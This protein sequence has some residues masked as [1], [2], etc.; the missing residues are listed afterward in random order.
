M[1]TLDAADPQVIG[2]Y[3][4]L[5]RLGSGGMGT[6]YL[7]SSRGGHRLAVKVI[8]GEL[9]NDPQFRV[10]F[11][12]EVEAAKRVRGHVTAAFVDSDTKALVPWL[13]TVYVDG[14]TLGSVVQDGPLD[15][16]TLRQLAAAVSEALL[17]IHDAG[18]VHRDL[19]PS[20]IILASDGARVIDFG[21]AQAMD[22]TSLTSTHTRIGSP[23][24]IAP[25]QVRDGTSSPAADVFSLG[26]VLAFA[27]TGQPV[28][29]EGSI[30][31][32]LYRVVHEQPNLDGVPEELRPLIQG[33]LAKDPALRPGLHEVLNLVTG[34]SSHTPTKTQVITAPRTTVMPELL[35]PEVAAGGPPTRRY[36]KLLLATGVAALLVAAGFIAAATVSSPDSSNSPAAP[37]H[38]S[39]QTSRVASAAPSTASQAPTS[40]QAPAPS[41]V[42][43]PPLADILK[44]AGA[45]Q[46]PPPFP[47]AAT[48]YSFSRSVQTTVRAFEGTKWATVTD[49]PATM[50]GCDQQRFYIR[51]RSLNPSA[52]IQATFV[53]S[54]DDIVLDAPVTGT[55][56]WQS[57]Y[58]CGQPAFRLSSTAS[59]GSTL[60][61][62]VVEYQ[63]WTASI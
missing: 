35:A 58:G 1:E 18:L 47:T 30:D 59:D 26:A 42:Q 39:G 6:V 16:D 45:G 46:S 38:P 9:A 51:W 14:P 11:E 52:A 25:E 23:G 57:G 28:F 56:G 8:R 10:R 43:W 13:A 53:S 32:V 37:P 50:N 15:V 20:N 41:P 60:A 4:V 24:F 29:G 17:E 2:P 48:G 55:A 34:A 36:R 49:F 19:K 5:G 22:A 63:V 31:S 12:R 21:I 54:P 33:C 40:A 7:C 3:R 44:V 27:A 61:D 62:V